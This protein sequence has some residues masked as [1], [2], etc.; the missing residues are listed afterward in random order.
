PGNAVHIL[1][2][3]II[4]VT[5]FLLISQVKKFHHEKPQVFFLNHRPFISF[6]SRGAGSGR[7]TDD[8]GSDGKQ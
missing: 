8:D 5:I 7:I 2:F 6:E 4:F 1:L 3:D